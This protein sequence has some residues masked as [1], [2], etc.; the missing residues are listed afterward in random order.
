MYEL[1]QDLLPSTK[2]LS[3]PASCLRLSSNKKLSQQDLATMVA[4]VGDFDAAKA[5]WAMP[6]DRQCRSFSGCEYDAAA[7]LR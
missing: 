5:A 6:S 7:F 2:D 4:K 1:M 3:E